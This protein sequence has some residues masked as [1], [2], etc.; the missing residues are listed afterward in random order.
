MAGQT[1]WLTDFLGQISTTDGVPLWA[2]HSN[3]S[4][5]CLGLQHRTI[6]LS[7]WNLH[8]STVVPHV[9]S[10]LRSRGMLFK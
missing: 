9:N 2:G 8:G 4:L 7:T 1:L 6:K 10:L 5:T 3:S